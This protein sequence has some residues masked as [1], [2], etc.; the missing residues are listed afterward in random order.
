MPN[1]DVLL[2]VHLERP[3]LHNA[4]YVPP[5]IQNEIID[6]IGKSIIQKSLLNEEKEAKLFALMV[7]EITSFNNEMMSLCVRFVDSS[8]NVRE[9]FLLFSL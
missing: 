7:D 9:E 4:T 3:R 8:N 2:K 1:H 5:R 6:V